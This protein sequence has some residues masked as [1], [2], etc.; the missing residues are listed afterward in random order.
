[1]DEHHCDFLTRVV[2]ILDRLHDTT[3]VEG[4]PF[5]A[6]LLFIAKSEAVDALRHIKELAENDRF[7]HGSTT[8][9]WRT[10]DSEGAEGIAA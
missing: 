6:S 9:G 5:L 10:R 3:V 4:E 1:M 8:A 2:G 7:P